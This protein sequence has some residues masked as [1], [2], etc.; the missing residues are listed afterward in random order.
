MNYQHMNEQNANAAAG[1]YVEG[2]NSSSS[3]MPAPPTNIPGNAMGPHS[4]RTSGTF[5]GASRK[6]ELQNEILEMSS[7]GE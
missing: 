4:P 3:A 5:F 2:A 1:G 7:F 6:S